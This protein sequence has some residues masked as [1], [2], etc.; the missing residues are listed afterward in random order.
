MAAGKLHANISDHKCIFCIDND[1]LLSKK[2]VGYLK[3]IIAK[4]IY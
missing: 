3:E 4:E 2:D 1:I